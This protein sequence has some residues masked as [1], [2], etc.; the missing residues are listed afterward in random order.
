MIYSTRK[1]LLD[2]AYSLRINSQNGSYYYI[3]D[4]VVDI[5]NARPRQSALTPTESSLLTQS[6]PSETEAFGASPGI[7]RCKT[8]R[9][10]LALIALSS[11][12]QFL[13]DDFFI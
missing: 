4:R 11:N 6:A 10:F 2:K 12:G 13:E 3:V 7:V 5:K 8:E 9:A 1:I